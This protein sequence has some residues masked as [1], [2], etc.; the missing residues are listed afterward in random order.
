MKTQF[1]PGIPCVLHKDPPISPPRALNFRSEMG[2][3]KGG[4]AHLTSPLPVAASGGGGGCER[5]AAG[6]GRASGA[7]FLCDLPQQDLC[8]FYLD[9]FTYMKD[10]GIY[11]LFRFIFKGQNHMKV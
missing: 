6:G 1:F 5:R 3:R 4:G 8:M 7:N 10:C 11:R 9:V 2:P